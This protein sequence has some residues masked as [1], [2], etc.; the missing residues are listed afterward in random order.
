MTPTGWQIPPPDKGYVGGDLLIEGCTFVRPTGPV[1]KLPTGKNV[2]FRN[3]T[4]DLRGTVGATDS[5]GKLLTDG[6]ENVKVEDIRY[7][8]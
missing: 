3:S 5:A 6:A 2:I 7:L 4:I 1:L 8:R